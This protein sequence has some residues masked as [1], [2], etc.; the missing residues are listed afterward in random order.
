[1]TGIETALI[2]AA[3]AS[4]AAAAA[5]GVAS[6]QQA[7][8]AEQSAEFDADVAKYN[9]KLSQLETGAA[10]EDQRRRSRAM[11]STLRSSASSRGLALSGSA[12]DLYMESAVDAELD[13]LEIRRVGAVQEKGLR[14]QSAAS[15]F[16]AANHNLGGKIGAGASVLAVGAAAAGGYAR[17]QN[18]GRT[19]PT[20]A[21]EVD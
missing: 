4:T 12:W 17:Y 2:I 15:K 11:L 10:E 16:S 7:K 14:L 20:A 9:A 8:A 5:S 6:Y 18:G 1:M 3:V 21:I 13:A 19:T